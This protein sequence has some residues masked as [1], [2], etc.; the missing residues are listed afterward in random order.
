MLKQKRR[1]YFLGLYIADE[2]G[3]DQTDEALDPTVT[4]ADNYTDAAKDRNVDYVDVVFEPL[5]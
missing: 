1:K 4:E 5:Y 2:I 3:G